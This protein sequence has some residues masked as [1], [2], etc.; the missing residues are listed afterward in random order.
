MQGNCQLR[1]LTLPDVAYRRPDPG[2]EMESSPSLICDRCT[3]CH[4]SRHAAGCVPCGHTENSVAQVSD[5]MQVP[6]P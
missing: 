1:C 4:S 3:G 5:N 2:W 6:W